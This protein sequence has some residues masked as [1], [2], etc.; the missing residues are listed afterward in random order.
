MCTSK[1]VDA[2]LRDEGGKSGSSLE[3]NSTMTIARCA[4]MENAAPF[5]AARSARLGPQQDELFFS[6]PP[7]ATRQYVQAPD[8][9]RDVAGADERL[10]SGDVRPKGAAVRRDAAEEGSS[11]DSTPAFQ[12]LGFSP[13]EVEALRRCECFAVFVAGRETPSG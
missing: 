2:P 12:P 13:L 1:V 9:T 10:R 11:C 4:G 7:T 8:E 5:A 3:K 6:L